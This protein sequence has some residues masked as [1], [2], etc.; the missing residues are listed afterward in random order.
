MLD[1]KKWHIWYTQY[2]D[3]GHEIGSGVYHKEYV[4]WGNAC[5]VAEKMYADKP[6]MS[7][8][9]AMRN[10][11]TVYTRVEKCDICGKEYTA[12]ETNE[13]W[14]VRN[15]IDITWKGKPEICNSGGFTR[16]PRCAGE[17][18]KPCPACLTLVRGFIETIKASET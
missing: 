16:F 4:N 11:W 2:D 17:Y 5:R 9:V 13:G 12:Y 10:P 15:R 14:P 3:E 8:V 7:Y 1:E 6:N 18:Y